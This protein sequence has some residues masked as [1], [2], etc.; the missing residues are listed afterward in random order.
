MVINT[1]TTLMRDITLLYERIDR[2]NLDT[3]KLK[4]LF[5]M[6]SVSMDTPDILVI[7]YP[8]L[9]LIIQIAEQHIRITHQQQSNKVDALALWDVAEICQRLAGSKHMLAYGFNYD[10]VSNVDP[11]VLEAVTN[12]WFFANRSAVSTL[13]EG[14]IVAF[15]PRL[16]FKRSGITY[17]LLLEEIAPG[18][19]KSHLNAHFESKRLP[20]KAQLK[21]SFLAEY[22][23]FSTLLHRLFDGEQG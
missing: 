8:P 19:L 13:L 22:E 1:T 10:I 12:R 7:V 4:N 20:P 2:S 11:A 17:D 6:Q 3:R 9:Q 23:K 15:A 16:K 14:D 18:M 21:S 5:D